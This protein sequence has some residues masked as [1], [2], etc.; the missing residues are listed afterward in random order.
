MKKFFFFSKKLT[1]YKGKSLSSKTI[2]INI[3]LIIK[4]TI[5]GLAQLKQQ[6]PFKTWHFNPP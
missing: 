5:L 4:D 2:G 1:A 6:K 3:F